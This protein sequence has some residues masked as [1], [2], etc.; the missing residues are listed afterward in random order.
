MLRA[1]FVAA[2]LA[3]A[4]CRPASAQIAGQACQAAVTVSPS[5]ATNTVA[6]AGVAGQNIFICGVEAS[7]AGTGNFYLESATAASCGGTLTQVGTEYYTAADWIKPAGPYFP[8]L[9][10]GQGNGLCV[11]TT[12]AVA[13]SV[14]VWYAQHP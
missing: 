9:S 3:F 13:I 14:T 8:G 10:T 2:I 5:T 12:A 4:F 7:S 1:L 6:V 11:H